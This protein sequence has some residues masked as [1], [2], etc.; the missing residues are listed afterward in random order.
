MDD[1]V[2]LEPKL[3]HISFHVIL[4]IFVSIGLLVNA[5]AFCVWMFG[6]KSKAICC[7]IYF[8]ANSAVDFL[9]LTS[10]LIYFDIWYDG[11]IPT[12]DFICK[13]VYGF[14][15]SCLQMSTCMSAIITV[16]R[17]LMIIFPF[18]FKT[19]GMQKRSKIVTLVIIVLQPFMQFI[20]LYY[21][22]VITGMVVTFPFH[23][24]KCT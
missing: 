14:Y 4:P 11:F 8:A 21:N 19:K 1:Y 17:S 2:S 23:I 5:F 3:R 7:A 12:T 15:D 20:T 13:F 24:L 18:V 6:P 9:Y 22:R 16:E 10:P